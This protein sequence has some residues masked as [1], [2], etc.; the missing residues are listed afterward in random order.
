ME[1]FVAIKGGKL[2]DLECDWLVENT[3]DTYTITVQ[4]KW[5]PGKCGNSAQYSHTEL[6]V[7]FVDETDATAF[8]LRWV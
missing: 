7:R 4:E 2:G 3:T 5:N 6:V 1:Y 8:K